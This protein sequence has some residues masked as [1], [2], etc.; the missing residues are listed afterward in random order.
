MWKENQKRCRDNGDLGALGRR[1]RV[2]YLGL[3]LLL[4]GTGQSRTAGRDPPLSG[5]K[6]RALVNPFAS[7]VRE[8][9]VRLKGRLK[10]RK[11]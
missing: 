11:G 3:T 7:G 6:G 9:T 4:L 1:G 5:G 10:R 8:N 2:A